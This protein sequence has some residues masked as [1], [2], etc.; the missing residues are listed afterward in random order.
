MTFAEIHALWRILA[1]LLAVSGVLD[2]RSAEGTAESFSLSNVELLSA[3]LFM[4]ELRIAELL[5]VPLATI[6]SEKSEGRR[7]EG[8]AEGRGGFDHVVRT[9]DG[10]ALSS[11]SRSLNHGYVLVCALQIVE[12][13]FVWMIEETIRRQK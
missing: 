10:R 11:C 4:V 1:D 6:R 8:A 9:G 2:F 12:S 13:S 7:I 3:E 5:S